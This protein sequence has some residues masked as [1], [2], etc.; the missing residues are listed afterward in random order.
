MALA[1]PPLQLVIRGA[2]PTERFVLQELQR[3]SALV[4]ADTRAALLADPALID[5]PDWHVEHCLVAE[6]GGR[7]VG[8]AV[9]LPR[10]GG[11][12]ELDGLFVEPGHWRE[13]IGAALIAAATEASRD[14]GAATLHVVA[15]LHALAFYRASG[16]IDGALIDMQLSEALEMHLPLAA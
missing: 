3:R 15:S 10:A 2:R 9:V 4:Y 12:A 13:G 16:F 6:R 14:M 11:E 7:T 5:L 1:A 8:F